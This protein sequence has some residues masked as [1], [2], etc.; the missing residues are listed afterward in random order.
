[1][2][3]ANRELYGTFA[4]VSRRARGDPPLRHLINVVFATEKQLVILV[5]PSDFKCFRPET[6]LCCKSSG[7]WKWNGHGK[8]SLHLW[9]IR[10]NFFSSVTQKEV[11]YYY[12]F[13]PE[14]DLYLQSRWKIFR[15]ENVRNFMLIKLLVLLKTVFT[16]LKT[17]FDLYN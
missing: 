2:L 7:G 5:Y 14:G 10:V 3:D 16:I 17:N 15:A 11:N 8:K 1:M 12:Y 6:K 4:L 13:H 9:T